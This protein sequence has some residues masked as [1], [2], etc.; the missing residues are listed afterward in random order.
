MIR[1]ID[2]TAVQHTHAAFRGKPKQPTPKAGFLA[3]TLHG[4]KPWP[5][6]FWIAHRGAGSLAPENTLPAIELGSQHGYRMFECDVRLSADGVPFLL[7]DDTLDRT[8]SGHG[9]AAS[10]FWKDLSALDAGGWHSPKYAG[11]SLPTL[12]SVLLYCLEHRLAV[13]LELKP[14]P[15]QEIATGTV[16]AQRIQELWPRDSGAPYPLL[17]SFQTLALDAAQA[18]APNLPKGLLL[19]TLWTGWL[20]KALEL[21]C[22]AIVAHHSLWDSA[23]LS[24]A[25]ANHLRALSYTVNDT[26][27]GCRLAELGLDGL[28]TDR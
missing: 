24:Q 5:Y 15:G 20:K 3:H 27:T 11:A 28:I 8:T 25:H 2:V 19:D 18:V 4:M 23:L 7:H 10:A 1:A 14:S 16:V 6:P 12:D 26:A 21:D 13:N 22:A 17:S 9:P